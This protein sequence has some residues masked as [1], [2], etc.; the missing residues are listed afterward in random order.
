MKKRTEET[1]EESPS[2]ARFALV[3]GME[4]GR[5]RIVGNG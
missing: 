5:T 2:M 4:G 1:K 3:T